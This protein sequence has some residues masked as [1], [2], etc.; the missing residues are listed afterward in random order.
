M[1]VRHN[2]M[3]IS[4]IDAFC[5]IRGG[6][7]NGCKDVYFVRAIG[8][9]SDFSENLR[10]LD[11]A[12]YSGAMLCNRVSSMPIPTSANDVS[13]YNN[14]F[15]KCENGGFNVIE[16]KRT[17]GT[18]LSEILASALKKTL[19]IFSGAK[20]GISRSMQ[21]NFAVKLLY[22][23]DNIVP[24]FHG[25]Y[26]GKETVKICADNI[27]KI[28]EYLF[29]YMLT[30]CGFDVLLLQSREDISSD[31][32][33]YG[34]SVKFIIGTFSNEAVP[35][36]KPQNTVSKQPEC[37]CEPIVSSTNNVRVRIPQRADR[38]HSVANFS[39]NTPVHSTVTREKSMEELAGLASSVVMIAIHNSIGDVIGT[40][41][42]IMISE[43]GYILTNNHVARGGSFYSVRIEDDEE[44]YHTDEIIK[45]NPVIDLAVIRIDRRLAP[46]PIYNGKK[47]VRGQKVVAIGSPLGLFNSVSDGIISGFRL[48]DSVEMIQ[49]TAPISH[50]SSG[51]AILNMNG[52]VI[53]ISTAGFDAGQNLN[54]A[55]SYEYIN[56]FLMG[57]KN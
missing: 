25:R 37:V 17:A 40:G 24:E 51:G 45:Y 27:T 54:L 1:A 4:S 48:I 12:F 41:S 30:L 9:D 57:L 22:W 23:F 32:E 18:P 10:R 5:N 43:K 44:V 55:V 7:N 35:E 56:A 13:Y 31:L 3:N 16:V 29:F 28:Q 2:I 11:K 36:Y 20:Q 42:G 14:C 21:E 53:G 38:I 8:L 34:F 50:G 19:E 39:N 15:K 49:F 33:R 47:P 26:S 6:F 46:I 52:E